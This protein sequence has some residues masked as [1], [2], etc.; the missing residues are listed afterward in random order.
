[1]AKIL[2]MLYLVLISCVYGMPKTSSKTSSKI[3]KAK[4]YNGP[5]DFLNLNFQ[6]KY[7]F[8]NDLE[9]SIQMSSL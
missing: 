6:V 9:N 8:L 1:M 5:Y 4:D 7:C 3:T 2:F